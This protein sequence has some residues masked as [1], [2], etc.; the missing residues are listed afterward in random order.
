MTKKL[1][2]WIVGCF[3]ISISVVV[4]LFAMSQ[5]MRQRHGSFLR[6]F[7]PHPALEGD[8]LNIKYNSYYI[9]GGTPSTVYLGN[10]A[11][12]LHLL[13]INL[14]SLDTQYVSLKVKGIFDQ[15]FWSARV[16][17]DSPYFFVTDGA[18]PRIYIGSV[19]T[20]SADRFEYDT[21]SYY[22]DI[23]SINPK[24]YVVK[25]LRGSPTE[26]VIGRIT[27]KN[28]HFQFNPNV[29]KK[30]IDG[31]FCTDGMLHYNK[32]LSRIVYIYY[33]RNEFFVLDTTLNVTLKGHT[34]DTISKAQIKVATIGSNNQHTMAAPPLFVN[35]KSS[36][37]RN[38]LFINSNMIARNQ[39]ER[40]FEQGEVIDVYDLYTGQYELSFYIYNYWGSKRMIEFKVLEN[41][42]V[43]L[44]NKLIRI[45]DLSPDFFPTDNKASVL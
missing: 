39:G 31:L 23:V 5:D 10:Y 1:I 7:P 29:L 3:V 9:A 4:I 43:V 28:P 21:I 12:P 27:A 36:V 8:S 34:L 20:W 37:Y 24:M 41:K 25:T 14:S 2:V 13:E 35:K 33:Y 19:N 32:E 30:Q 18:I 42:I 26:N 44:Y 6:Q 17:V 40:A 22:R 45:F 11:S 38:R 15:K 16:M